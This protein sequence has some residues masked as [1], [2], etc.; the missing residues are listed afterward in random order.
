M[1]NQ[2]HTR[3]S[4][5]LL[6]RLKNP[7]KW[8]AIYTKPRAEDMARDHLERKDIHVY[9]PKIRECHY[10]SKNKETKIKP[11]FPNY[12]FAQMAYPDDY[13]AVIWAKGV[14]R[15][16]GNGGEPVPLDDSVVDFLKKQTAENGLVRPSQPF[17]V[18]NT[19][20]VK[21][22]P[23]AGLTGIVDGSIDEKGRIK[24]LMDFLKEGARIEMAHSFLE[25][26]S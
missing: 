16:V 24:V 13:Y 8:Y 6:D 18:G 7:R 21:K 12:L 26:C 15:I 17:K 4:N 20:R 11:L 25:R 23:L 9:L 10:S 5:A 1:E 22:G 14:K 3:R 19:V 2:T